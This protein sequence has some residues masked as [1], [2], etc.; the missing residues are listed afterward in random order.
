[1]RKNVI[2]LRKNNVILLVDVSNHIKLKISIL[3]GPHH[4]MYDNSFIK[5]FVLMY[6]LKNV[7][8]HGQVFVYIVVFGI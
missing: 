7:Q 5:P 3:I 4:G 2:I 1:M 8:I 6:K